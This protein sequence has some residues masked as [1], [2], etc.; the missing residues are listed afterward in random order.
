MKQRN[1][2]RSPGMLIRVVWYLPTFRESLSIKGSVRPLNMGPIGWPETSVKAT[3]QRCV[4]D[5]SLR[6][7]VMES[8]RFGGT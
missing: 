4:R 1:D 8:R 2:L 3:D 5:V 6:R 7:R